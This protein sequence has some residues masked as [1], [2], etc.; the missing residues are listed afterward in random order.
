[1][2]ISKVRTQD[3]R[4]PRAGAGK[5]LERGH[6]RPGAAAWPES[7]AKRM[8]AEA[9]NHDR[10][11]ADLSEATLCAIAKDLGG[12]FPSNT[13][14]PEQRF[15]MGRKAAVLRRLLALKGGAR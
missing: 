6:A 3:F 5:P 8:D 7:T 4:P 12:R 14:D 11:V 13:R 15:L 2:K 10:W 1:M 9:R